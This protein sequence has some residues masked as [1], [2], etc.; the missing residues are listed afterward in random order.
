MLV[1]GGGDERY[2]WGTFYDSRTRTSRTAVLRICI[3]KLP[4]ENSLGKA[5]AAKMKFRRKF[6]SF[7]FVPPE[8]ALTQKRELYRS[9]NPLPGKPGLFFTS[10]GKQQER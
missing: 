10:G 5:F 4:S 1:G 8:S 2:E 6:D 7:I 3:L 9:V